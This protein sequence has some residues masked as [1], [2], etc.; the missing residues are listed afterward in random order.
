MNSNSHQNSSDENNNNIHT[1]IRNNDTSSS[2]HDSIETNRPKST[3]KH[4]KRPRSLSSTTE[5]TIDSTII[6]QSIISDSIPQDSNNTNT[7]TYNPYNIPNTIPDPDTKN[8]LV[9]SVPIEK[10]CRWDLDSNQLRNT[11][12]DKKKIKKK[13]SDTTSIFNTNLSTLSTSILT[14]PYGQYCDVYCTMIPG[15]YTLITNPLTTSSNTNLPINHQQPQQKQHELLSNITDTNITT[16][17]SSSLSTDTSTPTIIGAWYPGYIEA[18]DNRSYLYT[19][20]SSINYRIRILPSQEI[21]LVPLEYL[22]PLSKDYEVYKLKDIEYLQLMKQYN[23]YHT[24]LSSEEE[25]KEE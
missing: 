14:L 25:P 20:T 8:N 12:K 17:S 5:S 1:D 15:T 19:S 13:L 6:Q 22:R 18:I 11:T 9:D 21:I 24:I 16:T 10:P 4:K 23:P 2:E 3:N 7:S